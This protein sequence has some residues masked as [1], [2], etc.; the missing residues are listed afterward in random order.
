[1]A[2]PPPPAAAG[3]TPA[4]AETA[5]AAAP[6]TTETASAKPTAG[7]G[8]GRGEN[9]IPVPTVGNVDFKAT[10]DAL[11]QTLVGMGVDPVAT[12]EAFK[13]VPKNMIP[14][15]KDGRAF[16]ALGTL[17]NGIA[18]VYASLHKTRAP[19]E[20]KPRV[21]QSEVFARDLKKL[22]AA[23]GGDEAKIREILGDDAAKYLGK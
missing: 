10:I 15:N 1:M 21:K 16:Y 4:P 5:P 9:Q 8:P 11:H 3:S 20:R 17:I 23:L 6:A 13:A 2:L 12:A 18:K 19:K 22:V 14:G 7:F